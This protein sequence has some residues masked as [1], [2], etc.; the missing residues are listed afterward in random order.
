MAWFFSMVLEAAPDIKKLFSDNK[1]VV[2]ACVCYFLSN[3]YFSP[4]DS[5]L[6]AMKSAFFHLK[7]SFHS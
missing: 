4:N 2:K 5:S 7:S 3:F 1:K 6:K